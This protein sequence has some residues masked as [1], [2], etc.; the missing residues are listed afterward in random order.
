MLLQALHM[1][2]FNAIFTFVNVYLNFK[3]IR[4]LWVEIT[5]RAFEIGSIIHSNVNSDNIEYAKRMLNMLNIKLRQS[6]LLWYADSLD[7]WV[8]E[9][10]LMQ[11]VLPDSNS[12]NDVIV[13]WRNSSVDVYPY[14]LFR[15]KAIL[16]TKCILIVRNILLIAI[17]KGEADKNKW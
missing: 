17:T 10:Q 12:C 15:N 14:F 4:W 11:T 2:L 7:N 13:Y 1:T 9:L 16:S 6:N 8:A 3:G 5:S